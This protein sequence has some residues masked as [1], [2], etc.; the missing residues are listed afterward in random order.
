MPR[1]E[2]FWTDFIGYV[3][4]VG[5]YFLL[6]CLCFW[7]ALIW[8]SWLLFGMGTTWAAVGLWWVLWFTYCSVR[9]S[10]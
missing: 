7:G 3:I 6:A 9:E 1:N 10:L 2:Q 8:E 5:I 4:V